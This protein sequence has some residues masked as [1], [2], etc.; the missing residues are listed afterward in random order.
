MLIKSKYRYYIFLLGGLILV[1]L[2]FFDKYVYPL[3][4]FRN[5]IITVIGFL[6]I[7]L[8]LL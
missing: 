7:I 5:T 8:S 6:L 4:L 2:P 3:G 1:I